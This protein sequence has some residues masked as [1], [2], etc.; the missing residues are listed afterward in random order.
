VWPGIALAL[1]C[2]SPIAATVAAPAPAQLDV[3]WTVE[4]AEQPLDAALR[5]LA[6]QAGL[7][8]LFEPA[9]V[10][11][12]RAPPLRGEWTSRDALAKLLEGT[13]LEAYEH[14]PGV[15][16][17]RAR[18]VPPRSAETNAR[19]EPP[20]PA[21]IPVRAP[22]EDVVVTAQRR[23]Q[24]L[25]EVPIS[26]LVESGMDLARRGIGTVQDASV[27]YPNVSI[28]PG[29]A[30]DQ[31]Y[32]RGVGSGINGGFEQSVGTFVDGIYRGRSR[33]SR[34]SLVDVERVEVLRG[35]QNLYFGNNA[36]GGA[37]NITTRRPGPAWDGYVQ[38]SWEFEAQESMLTAAAG[39]PV[40]DTLGVRFAAQYSDME[41][42]VENTTTGRK[43]PSPKHRL[44]RV[45]GVWSPTDGLAVALK[46]ERAKL[47]SSAALPLQI[48]DCPPPAP[49]PRPGRVCANALLDPRLEFEF[50]TRRSAGP[51]EQLDVDA[52]EAMLQ[53]RHQ[54]N[55]HELTATL[56]DTRYQYAY[57]GDTDFTA[58]KLLAFAVPETFDQQ[59]LEVR[60]TSPDH[61]RVTWIA[62]AYTQR[63]DLRVQTNVAFHFVTP[64]VEQTAAFAPLRPYTPLA[65]DVVLDQEEDTSAAFGALTWQVS[66]QVSATAGVRYTTVSKDARHVA[67]TKR[68]GDAFGQT[69]TPLPLPLAVLAATLTGTVPHDLRRSREDADLMPTFTLQYHGGSTM[70]YATYSEG[71]KAGGFDALELTGNVDRLTF[72]AETVRA[73]EIGSKVSREGLALNLAAFR[74]VYRDL[75]QSVAQVGSTG[76]TFFSVSNVGGLVSTGLEADL[77]WQ[78][79]DEWRLAAGSAWLRAT[80]RDYRNAGCTALQNLN[81]PDGRTCVQ[82]LTGQSPPFAPR[83]TGSATLEW[84]RRIGDL[85]VFIAPT[86]TFKGR[87]DVISDNEPAVR[88]SGFHKLD[89]RVGFVTPADAWEVALLGRNLTNELTSAFGQDTVGSGSHW[90]LLERPRSVALQVCRRW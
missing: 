33:Y 84:R 61:R 35:P 79:T 46:L 11:G 88:Q 65:N 7:Q 54:L 56:G 27:V 90:R 17:I 80:Y 15:L 72:D 64:T 71:F 81:T 38:A 76:T 26:I 24:P 63:S 82:D 60:L 53:L 74:N 45:Y 69:G 66:D 25:R 23:E 44:G 85:Q 55:G 4:L 59:S 62:G 5:G 58:A 32:I 47:T 51:G 29:P 83:Y 22:L 19:S 30:S 16:G 41:G 28:T 6:K 78:M 68:A 37:L 75:Q 2:V 87:Y 39:G 89:L 20:P 77:V 21:P 12:R 9:L 14:V 48:T 86:F 13:G 52:D 36:I 18:A 57:G 70:L 67:T 31:L 42:Y 1:G 73:T 49:F 3:R 50:D 34:G 40:T 8:L 43:D 10:A